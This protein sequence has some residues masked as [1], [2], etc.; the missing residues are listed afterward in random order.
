MVV[1]IPWG[2]TARYPSYIHFLKANASNNKD[3]NLEGKLWTLD[4]PGDD[5]DDG[6]GGGGGDVRAPPAA[7]PAAPPRC[8]ACLHGCLSWS[9][10]DGLRTC[11]PIMGV[12]GERMPLSLRRCQLLVCGVAVTLRQVYV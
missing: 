6:D 9:I 5:Q 8:R 1:I 7:A 3:R 10:T 11:G 4:S 2:A 12:F